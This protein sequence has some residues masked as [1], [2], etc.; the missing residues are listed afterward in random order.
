MRNSR[1]SI[2][3]AAFLDIGGMT[4]S[5][6]GSHNFFGFQVEI[7]ET[8]TCG[9]YSQSKGWACDCGHCR[10]FLTLA[11]GRQLPA[12]VLENLD[13]LGISPEKA[14]YVCEMY[15]DGEGLCY[16]FSYRIAGN[17][18]SGEVDRTAS[19]R[20]CHDPYPYGAPGFPEPHFDLEFWLTLPWVLDEPLDEP[21]ED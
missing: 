19:G 3:L 8:A 17:I 11:R 14:T 5:G 10:N 1:K 7:D 18:L 12:T 20:C 21:V 6:K 15:P 4:V 16:Q 2:R 9:W 13:K